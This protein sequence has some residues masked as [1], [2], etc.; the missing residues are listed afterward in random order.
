[1]S[2]KLDSKGKNVILKLNMTLNV[3]VHTLS[4]SD[5]EPDCYRSVIKKKEE[6]IL[7]IIRHEN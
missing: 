3:R 4:K 1:M 6:V 5:L 2:P 7:K